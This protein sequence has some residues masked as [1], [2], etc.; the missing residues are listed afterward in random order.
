M[1]DIVKLGDARQAVVK[2]EGCTVFFMWGQTCK[3]M[4]EK[5][6]PAPDP[7]PAP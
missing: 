6:L 5:L 4:D 7:F 2:F 3:W 1:S